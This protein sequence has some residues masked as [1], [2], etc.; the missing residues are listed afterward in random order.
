MV[1][2]C[3]LSSIDSIMTPTHIS[4]VDHAC[5]IVQSSQVVA[6]KA[7]HVYDF[8]LSSVSAELVSVIVVISGKLDYEHT[9]QFNYVSE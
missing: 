5:R 2:A 7:E 8:K 3:S 4:G 6:P 9:I 1:R